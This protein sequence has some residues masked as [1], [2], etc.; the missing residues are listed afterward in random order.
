MIFKDVLII[1]T[2]I[3]FKK[4]DLLKSIFLV[5]VRN[6]MGLRFI[7]K[8]A[9][10]K[11]RKFDFNQIKNFLHIRIGFLLTQY[12][13]PNFIDL[14]YHYRKDILYF[15]NLRK[16]PFKK[17]SVEEIYVNHFFEYFP[18]KWSWKKVINNWCSKLI[19]GGKLK[20]LLKKNENT[21]KKLNQ[22]IKLLINANLEILNSENNKKIK[23]D[24]GKLY[25]LTFFKKNVDRDFKKIKK[26]I[27]RAKLNN[28]KKIIN[29]LDGNDYIGKKIGI[30]GIN[31]LKFEDFYKKAK[32]IKFYPLHSNIRVNHEELFEY[33]IIYDS[34]EYLNRNEMKDFFQKIK[35]LL[36]PKSK[37]LVIVPYLHNYFTKDYRQLFN[38]AILTEL[39]DG[40]DLEIKWVNLD[41]SLKFV[42]MLIIN[43]SPYP[44]QI[45]PIK[46][47]VLGNLETRYS[48]L[49]SF[50]DG[51]I[52]ALIKLGYNP[53]LLDFRTT[54]FIEILRKIKLYQPDYLLTGDN[55]VKSF[56]IKYSDFFRKSKICVAYWYRDVREPIDFNFKGVI[57]FMFV[58]NQGQIQ[59]YKDKF[60]IENV[61]YMPQWSNP[62]FSHP[63]SFI[64]EK[65][66]IGFTGQIDFGR[67]HKERT[68]ILL[69]LKNSFDVKIENAE[70]NSISEFNSQCKIVFGN[71]MGFHRLYGKIYNTSDDSFN[72]F[73]SLY[74]SNRLFISIGCGACFF[75]NYFPGI[76]RLFENGK[77]LVWYKNYEEL[78]K[79]I[80]IYL[81]DDEKRLNIKRE[82]LKI[83]KERHTHIHRIKN[84]LDI[85]MGK[86]KE[87]YGF[88]N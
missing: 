37:I 50:W 56:L 22:L 82:A 32:Y 59:K 25:I 31:H 78:F 13:Y 63:N 27:T 74:A 80:K 4:N 26:S 58:T 17:K 8:F 85:I 3:I 60:Q 88:L 87:F 52:R 9:F 48:Q 71:D 38:K 14:D 79:F 41:S 24:T 70:F 72:K 53:L 84:G 5:F 10:K 65:Y 29:N 35:K 1:K 6:L 46:I 54:P 36:K 11:F 47:A 77:H 12:P 73:V 2:R 7:F 40:N 66:N 42:K 39:I 55:N 19:P 33:G 44:S 43:E 34:L 61:F 68:K 30:I 15:L 23:I 81:N 18:S 57:D 45:S 62:Q 83:A 21:N 86:T 49:N 16:L 76:E 51:Q 67:F 75:I 28:L 69:E 64:E 20:L